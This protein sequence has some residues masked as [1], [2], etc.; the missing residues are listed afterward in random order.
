M[1]GLRALA[2][3]LLTS[4]FAAGAR[5]QVLD[6]YVVWVVMVML[7]IGYPFALRWL[8]KKAEGKAKL[9]EHTI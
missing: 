9:E 3:A 5:T 1:C 4:I 7:A 2:P 6:G 8:P